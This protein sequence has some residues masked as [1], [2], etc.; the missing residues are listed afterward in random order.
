MRLPRVLEVHAG[1]RRLAAGIR[2][3]LA[4][5]WH[6]AWSCLFPIGIFAGLIVAR[7]F[8]PTLP[9]YDTMLAL[10]LLMQVGMYWG[11]LESRDE[12]K[13]ICV[14]H[15]LGLAMELWKVHHGSW[16]YPGPGYTK[17]GGVPL[18][19][20]FMYASIASYMCQA[21]RRLQLELV[22]WPP[23]WQTASLGAAIYVNFFTNRYLPDAR[24]LIIVAM[25]LVFRTTLV[26]FRPNGPIRRMPLITAFFCIGLF[27]WFGE[28]LGTFLDAWRYPHQRS[29]WQA[30]HLQKL[31]S[32]FLLVIVSLVLVA[33]LKRIKEGRPAPAAD[34]VAAS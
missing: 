18:Y 4:F 32:W 30:V 34:A 27:I 26:R 8:E 2:E 7:W 17:I 23:A 16:A 3:L 14:F 25:V 29:G 22:G 24:W 9:R 28:N 20:G 11:G 13:V 33:H 15:I 1:D 31:T 21:W 6:E 12:V 5:A 10:C 19:A